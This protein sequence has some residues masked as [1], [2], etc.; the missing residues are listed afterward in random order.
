MQAV[1][2]VPKFPMWMQEQESTFGEQNITEQEVSKEKDSVRT[3]NTLAY[4]CIQTPKLPNS[5]VA[6]PVV[7]HFIQVHESYF[8]VNWHIQFLL[9]I[10]RSKKFSPQTFLKRKLFQ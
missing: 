2:E 4:L 1:S 7:Y 10:N 6:I 3:A 5:K 9:L 8:L